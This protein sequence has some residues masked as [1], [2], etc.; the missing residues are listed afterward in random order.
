MEPNILL[1][2]HTGKM[3]LALQHAFQNHGTIIGRNSKDLDATDFDSITDLIFACRPQLVINTIAYMGID[4]CEQNPEQAQKIN[5]LLPR[6][7]ARLSAEHAFTLV[8]FSTDAVFNDD[9]TTLRGESAL[10]SPVNLYGVTKLGGEHMVAH[11]APHH[12]I[13]RLPVLFG[14]AIKEGQ[15]VEKMLR[16]VNNGAQ[17]LRISQD[18]ITSPSYSRDLARAV[19]QVV[20]AEQSFGLY[21]LCNEGKASLYDL[22]KEIVNQLGL[23]VTV[24]AASH[25]D[26]PAVGEKNTCT[27]MR[28]EKLPP[29]RPWQEAVAEYCQLLK[30]DLP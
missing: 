30:E 27:P 18:I 5:T 1:L 7:L 29:L 19:R 8:H 20:L 22:M 6:H 24:Q 17:S 14:P 26:F 2:G 13:F 10:P 25:R 3:G 28:S 11:H 4:A 23:Q 16:L 12:Y 15:F 21:H 9:F